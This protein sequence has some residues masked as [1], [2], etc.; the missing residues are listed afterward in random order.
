[1]ASV[2]PH[3]GIKTNYISSVVI[4]FLICISMIFSDTFITFSRSS[5]TVSATLL[6]VC[7]LRLKK[8]TCETGK[9]VFYFT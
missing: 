1:M 7:F 9:N 5:K 6:L 2:V 4:D 3:R 8:S